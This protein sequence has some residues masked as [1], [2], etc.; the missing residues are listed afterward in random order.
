[1]P[2]AEYDDVSKKRSPLQL[3]TSRS[4]LEI[5]G[6]EILSIWEERVRNEVNSAGDLLRP[7]LR[8]ALPRF[9]ALLAEALSEESSRGLFQEASDIVRKHAGERARGSG[10]SPS[11]IVQEFQAL[12]EIV[13]SY[14]NKTL[15]LSTKDHETIQKTFDQAIQ[16]ALMEFFLVHASLREQFTA[17]LS[18]D[19]RNPIAVAKMG[20]QLIQELARRVKEPE[21]QEDFMRLAG[22]IVNSMTRADR[23]IQDLLD[24][25]ILR[26]GEKFPIQISECDLLNV[27]HEVVSEAGESEMHRIHISGSSTKGYWDCDGLRRSLENLIKNAIKY[28]ANDA[29]IIVKIERRAGRVYLSVHNQG[30]PIPEQEH[31]L[32]F[33]AF[34]RSKLARDGIKP[35]W[36][37]GLALVR[38]VAESLGGTV[39]LVS[40]P[41]EGTTFTIELPEDSRVFQPP[42]NQV[43]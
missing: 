25:S 33:R 15:K 43:H 21:L 17:T 24:A 27:A 32:I 41:S 8:D 36:G 19:L 23:M 30:N 35:G 37:I 1:M 10:Y 14:L 3:V 42:V 38:A 34:G 22:R 18:H 39:T 2:N 20:G 6:E 16:E 11:Q 28:G 7:A 13:T 31:K 5:L 40:S 9:L 26:I 4:S 12:R 29:L